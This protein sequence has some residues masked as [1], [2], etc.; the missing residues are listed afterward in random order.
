[1]NDLQQRQLAFLEDTITYYSEDVN[2]RATINE[3]CMYRTPDGKK[4]AIGRYIPDDKYC[5]DYE[6]FNCSYIIDMLPKEIQEFNM[7]FLKEIQ[8]LHD[9]DEYWTLTGLSQL[10]IHTVNCIKNKFELR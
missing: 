1:M 6:G 3:R 9:K 8:R 4:C 10:G 5:D 2:R 7:I